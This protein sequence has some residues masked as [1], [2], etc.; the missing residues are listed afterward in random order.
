LSVGLQKTY[1]WIKTQVDK[2]KLETKWI[3]ESPDGGKTIYKRE[4]QNTKKIKIK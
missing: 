3:Y 1:Q 2:K 4:L